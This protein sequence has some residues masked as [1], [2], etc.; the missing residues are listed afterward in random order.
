M[1]KE[2]DNPKQKSQTKTIIQTRNENIKE[3]I[4]GKTQQK[5]NPKPKET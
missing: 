4:K 2:K 3:T 5:Q 1:E